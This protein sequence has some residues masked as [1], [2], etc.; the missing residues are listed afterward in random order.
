MDPLSEVVDRDRVG[1]RL[2]V[3]PRRPGDRFHPL[4]A[5]GPCKVKRFLAE[6]RVPRALRDRLAIVTVQ[7][8]AGG[9]VVWVAGLRLGEPFRVTERTRSGLLLRAIPPGGDTGR[10]A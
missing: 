3:R 9:A 5:P 4:G 7:E 8:E 10:R 6:A 2:A 1:P